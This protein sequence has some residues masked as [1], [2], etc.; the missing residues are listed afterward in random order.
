MSPDMTSLIHRKVAEKT[1]GTFHLGSG[2][3]ARRILFDGDRFQFSTDPNVEYFPDV[4]RWPDAVPPDQLD[5]LLALWYSESHDLAVLLSSIQHFDES[6]RQKLCLQQDVSNLVNAFT[7]HGEGILFEEQSGATVKI[8]CGIDATTVL[9]QLDHQMEILAEAQTLL[10]AAEE[11]LLLSPGGVQARDDQ[12]HWCFS[13]I[14]MLVDGFRT[15]REIEADSPFSPICTLHHLAEAAREGWL[16]KKKFPELARVRLD[17]ID[18]AS[19]TQFLEKLQQATSMAAEPIKILEKMR[20]LHQLSGDRHAKRSA[21]IRIVDA[22]RA[23]RDHESAI[24]MLD[25]ILI[26]KPED[27]LAHKT[28]IEILVERAEQLLRGSQ[29]EEGRRY[30]RRAIEV[31]DED[32]LRLQLIASHETPSMQIREGVRIASHLHRSSHRRRALRMIDSLEA[33]HPEQH[34]MQ[35]AKIDFLLDHGEE[36]ASEQALERLAARQASEGNI[37]RARQ[38]AESVRILRRNRGVEENQSRTGQKALQRIRMFCMLA[39][40]LASAVILIYAEFSLQ[41]VIASADHLPP[42]QWREEAKPWLQWLPPGPWKNGLDRATALV[43]KR[44]SDGRSH[45]STLAQAAILDA[46]GAR[47]LGHS[48]RVRQ[49]LKLAIQYGA[50][51]EARAW[52]EKWEVEDQ[53]ATVLR[54]RTEVA[55]SHGNLAEVRRIN[56][57]LLKQFPSNDATTGLTIPVRIET[58]T[59][60]LLILDSGETLV[61]PHWLEVPPFGSRQ[62]H[63]ESNGKRSTFVITAEGPETILLPTP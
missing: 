6:S 44:K 27:D 20:Q 32:Q 2:H 38:I 40:F 16:F 46:K 14:A 5:S 10:P 30:L 22:H 18:E 47:I 19:R 60:A 45:Y 54:K 9:E 57:Q 52:M 33:L 25:Q 39:P 48:D 50:D 41:H 11:L 21:E 43:E 26:E 13:R 17:Q 15:I 4:S 31:S 23:A 59:P 63:L 37:H 61:A 58:N 42:D 49:Q 35:Q 7:D 53:Q 55:R 36:Q 1:V 28:R 8:T 34:E 24:A 29:P 51:A 12:S 56:F 62:I 3:S